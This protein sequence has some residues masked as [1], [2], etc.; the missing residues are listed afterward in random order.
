MVIKWNKTA[1]QQ[2]LDAIR[3]IEENEFFSYAEE[4]EKDILSRIRNLS[5]NPTIYPLNKYRRNNDGTYHAFEVDE[6]RISYRNKPDEIRI[7]R[8]RHTSR[9]V[10]K[11]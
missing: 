11:Y 3:F 6:Y 8:I 5:E 9:K 7:I 4:L 1:V 2:L 10:R